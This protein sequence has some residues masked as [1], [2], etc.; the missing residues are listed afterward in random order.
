APAAAEM[1]GELKNKCPSLEHFMLAGTARTG[2]QSLNDAMVAASPRF[3]ASHTA[4]DEPAICYYTSGTTRE[5]K[6]VLHSHAY[7]YSHRFTGLNWLGLEPADRH[8]TTSDTGWA[9]AAYGVLFG[10]WMNGVTTFMYHG[11]FDAAKELE[12]LERY[13]V[14][15]FCAPPTEY[16][17]LIKENLADY[18]FPKLRHC[19]GA[20]EPLNPEVIE[21]WRERLGLTIHDGYGQTETTI[22]AAN[23][24]AMPVKAGS[25]GLPFPGHDVRVI[26]NE[27]AETKV[28]ELGEIAVRVSPERPPSLFLEYWKN[29]EETAQVFRGDWYLTGDQA[30]RDADGYLWFVGRADDVIISAGYRIGPFEVES[31]LLEHPAVLESAVVAS[32]DADRGSIVKAFV[33]LRPGA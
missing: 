31:A 15:T 11:R 17:I 7:T 10:P 13:G 8:W 33:K 26:D 27:M 12:L 2:W 18:S 19:T 9:K 20:G 1:V 22:L 16:R 32:P 24:P 4:A 6:A 3:T 29:A 21:V 23:L 14:T 28:D 30:T 25:M 5:P